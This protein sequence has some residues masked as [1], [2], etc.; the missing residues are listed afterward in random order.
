MRNLVLVSI[1]ALLFVGCGESSVA[2][3][4]IPTDISLQPTSGP[5]GISVT[6]TGKGFTPANNIIKIDSG[7]LGS[8][9]NSIA[10]AGLMGQSY[11]T[12]IVPGSLN[13]CRPDAACAGVM[14]LIPGVHQVSVQ[15]ANG[16]SDSVQFTVTAP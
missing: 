14:Q 12:F 5:V 10:S 7:F 15:N 6:I 2:P 1:F 16:I 9:Y 8:F 13:L 4:K 11:I 3:S